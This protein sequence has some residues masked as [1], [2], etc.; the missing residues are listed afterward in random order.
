MIT[1]ISAI[2][3]ALAKH[4]HPVRMGEGV[5]AAQAVLNTRYI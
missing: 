5:A 2:E 4:G 1:A 3:M